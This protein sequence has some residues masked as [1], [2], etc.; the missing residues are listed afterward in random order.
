[1]KV[2]IATTTFGVFS[3]KPINL[4]KENGFK[5]L[6][7]KKKRK[8]TE[9]EIKQYIEDCDA[10]IA[11]T[12]KYSKDVIN[13]SSKLK[14][15][16]RL[17]V[18]TDNIDIKSSKIK[19]IKILKT[20]SSPSRSVAEL[21][22]GLILDCTRHITNQ[23]NDLKANKWS[24]QTGNLFSYKKVGIIGL[25]SIGKEFV[26]ITKGFNLEYFAYDK[27]KDFIF[28]KKNNIKFIS[29]KDIFK[30]CDIITIHLNFQTHNEK[31]IN[32]NLLSIIKKSAILINTSRGEII[33]EKALLEALK[34]N[35]LAAIGLD[36]FNVEPYNGKL[37][38]YDNAILTPHI[39]SYSME[40][41]IAMEYEAANN[42]IKTL[43]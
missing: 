18:G 30:D 22:L 34:N 29:L 35:N 21:A 39:G 12:E 6:F 23:S 7:N 2:F 16:S 14:V 13:N 3:K 17:G 28:A 5:V 19:K 36:V 32:K 4:L 25:G 8:L 24:K 20:Q 38:K 31:I 42:I 43:K 33:D 41:R 26:K 40:V 10:V 37:I 1:M 9:I 27:N 11:G 15:I